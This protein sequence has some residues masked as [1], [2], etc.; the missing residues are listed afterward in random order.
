MVEQLNRRCG[1]PERL[2]FVEDPVGFP[3]VQIQHPDATARISLYGGQVLSFQPKSQA[4]DLLFLSSQAIFQRGTAIRG[5]IPLCWPWF[6]PD[7]D[8]QGRPSHGLAR[9]Q[10]WTVLK[11]DCLPEGAIEVQLGLTSDDH[12]LEIW[13]V[14]FQLRLTV[15]LSQTL[16]LSLESMNLGDQTLRMTQAL[17][18]YLRIGGLQQMRIT[19]L[20]D[21]DYL[22]KVDQYR[23]KFQTGDLVIAG[24]VD[25]IYLTP[26]P[27]VQIHDPVLRR[28]LRVTSSGGNA[29]VVWNPGPAGRLKDLGSQDYEQFVC[30]ETA[31]A[32]GNPVELAPREAYTICAL[33]QVD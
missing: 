18:T 5:G 6:G 27:T 11:T 25:R 2:T 13:P 22:D 4:E 26:P 8:Q 32:G 19:G 7:P 30:V 23:R 10:F 33:Y 17:H 3:M 20:A 14:P 16:H 24:E 12:T 9:T 29:V 28:T 21:T 31:N 1:L 15:T